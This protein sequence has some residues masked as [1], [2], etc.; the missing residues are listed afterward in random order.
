MQNIYNDVL[1]KD[2]RKTI[3]K[4]G[5]IIENS[6]IMMMMM[7]NERFYRIYDTGFNTCLTPNQKESEIGF[8]T[9]HVCFMKFNSIYLSLTTL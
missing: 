4:M 2:R 1:R 5:K 3:R 9:H 6:G 8:E 7:M